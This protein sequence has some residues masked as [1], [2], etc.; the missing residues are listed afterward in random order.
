M[1]RCVMMLVMHS[2]FSSLY[3]E[4]DIF[5]HRSKDIFSYNT[6]IVHLKWI[7]F[8]SDVRL[9]VI[10]TKALYPMCSKLPSYTSISYSCSAVWEMESILGHLLPPV[11]LMIISPCVFPCKPLQDLSMDWIT[12]Q[13]SQLP[14]NGQG[15]RLAGTPTSR[16]WLAVGTPDCICS[17]PNMASVR[18]RL[19][20]QGTK[21]K[22]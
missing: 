16:S 15:V 14:G 22:V 2:C 5:E 4:F 3:R 7:F 8:V 17:P 6:L 10:M 1:Q 12:E 19:V 18:N 21:M 20:V 11:H 13:Q 9:G